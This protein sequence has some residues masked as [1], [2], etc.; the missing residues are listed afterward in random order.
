MEPGSSGRDS[1]SYSLTTGATIFLS[2]L[3]RGIINFP[4]MLVAFVVGS[5][6]QLVDSCDGPLCVTSSPSGGSEWIITG[7]KVHN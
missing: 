6:L 4:A 7:A 3:T 1:P 2:V 5:K